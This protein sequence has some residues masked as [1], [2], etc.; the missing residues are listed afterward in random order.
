MH[1]ILKHIYFLFYSLNAYQMSLMRTQTALEESKGDLEYARF[2]EITGFKFPMAAIGQ[3]F[4]KK[5]PMLVLRYR[6]PCEK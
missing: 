6:K 3:M 2:P 5:L 4:V 1:P